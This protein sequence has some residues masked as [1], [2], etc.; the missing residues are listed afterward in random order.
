MT[1]E[2]KSAAEE[3]QIGLLKAQG[4][5]LIVLARYMQILSA[6][7]VA[8]YPRRII[9]VHHSF[10]PAFMGAK[11]Y[12]AAFRRG[13]KLIGA[14]SHYVTAAL[15]DAPIIEQDVL[16]VSHR[17]QVET[18]IEKGRDIERSVLSRAVKWHLDHRIL[19]YGNKTVVF[20]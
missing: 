17:D 14:T 7:F 10:L 3:E 6:Q 15:D 11:P 12:H 5:D 16:R 9:N 18:L 13:V 2:T 1:P 4:I 19:A 8:Q 20:D